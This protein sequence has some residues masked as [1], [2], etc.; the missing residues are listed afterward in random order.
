M[1]HGF[2]HL[3]YE[4]R[5]MI[6]LYRLRRRTDGKCPSCKRKLAFHPLRISFDKGDVT[7]LVY[8]KKLDGPWDC[9][10][11]CGF[12]SWKIKEVVEHENKEH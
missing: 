6:P 1:C 4:G 5:D 12:Q 9:S 7:H 11:N 10:W 2:G 8:R 3:L